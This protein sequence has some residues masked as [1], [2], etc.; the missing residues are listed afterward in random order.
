[1]DETPLMDTPSKLGRRVLI[2][3]DSRIQAKILE[4]FLVQ[5]GY[6][7][8]VASDGAAA[9]RSAQEDRPDV[10][11]SDIEM[12][13][14]NGYELCRA[15]KHSPDLSNVPVVLLSTLSDAE[16][17]IRGLDAGAD[18]YVTKPY[19]PKYLIGRL[20]S[21]LETPMERLQ[22]DQME[23]AVTLGG[24][25]YHVKSGRQQT[26]NLLVSTFEN[27]VEKNR[28][29]HRSNE[30]LTLAKERLSRSHAELEKLN[31]R[32]TVANERMEHDLRAAA[33]VQQSLLPDQKCDVPAVRVAWKYQPCHELA[34]DFLNYFMLDDRYLALFVVDVSGHG[35]ASS[36]LAVA[37]GRVLNPDVSAT[38]LLA[39]HDPFTG[40]TIVTPP[41]A[42][43]D[44]LN[45]RF[46][47]TS[48]GELYFT[49]AYGILDTATGDLR[50]VSAGHPPLVRV[51]EGKP[52]FLPGENFAVGWIDDPEYEEAHVRLR[53]GDRIYFYS[54]G[55][56][57][58][59]NEQNEQLG[60]D[61]LFEMI[62]AQAKSP[63][64]E[65]VESMLAAVNA[66]CRP[67][68]PNDD[69]SILVCQFQGEERARRA[70]EDSD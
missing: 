52:S 39:R 18:N 22:E 30:M 1:M 5:A 59:M 57:E 38:S 67:N 53:P 27:A 11:V 65:G 25:Q 45:R 33:R 26:L 36:L 66:W 54:D 19:D 47:M 58:A 7:V 16:D 23:L 3:E 20:E 8:R 43:L 46:Q 28:E 62:R 32:L 51:S 15:I 34:G 63:V 60:N 70:E 12:P 17:I 14:M 13:H 9:L 44:E 37:V 56:N 64:E 24:R 41:A 10:V 49:I 69:V 40:R 48:Q 35:A 68:S 4:Q 61:R 21:L 42:V 31:A 2:A 55:V 29:L 50:Y 6:Q